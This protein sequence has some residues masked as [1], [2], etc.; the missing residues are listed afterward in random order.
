MSNREL[1]WIVALVAIGVG[2][3]QVAKSIDRASVRIAETQAKLEAENVD[4]KRIAGEAIK[5][6]ND[7]KIRFRS[8]DTPVGEPLR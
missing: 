5:A 8:G 2:L 6:I 1:A 7:F 3:T 4:W